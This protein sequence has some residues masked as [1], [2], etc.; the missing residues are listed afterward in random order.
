MSGTVIV[1]PAKR[2]TKGKCINKNVYVCGTVENEMGIN[3]L[4]NVLRFDGEGTWP[5]IYYLHYDL[6]N[7]QFHM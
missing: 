1:S 4:K 3:Y 7:S 5:L 6:H 2:K